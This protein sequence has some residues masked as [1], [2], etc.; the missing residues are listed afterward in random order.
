MGHTF[1]DIRYTSEGEKSVT[2]VR[3]RRHMP[4]RPL[5]VCR[6]C[7]TLWPCPEAQRELLFASA[8]C[9]AA[10]RAHL[11]TLMVEADRQLTALRPD[12]APP[13]AVLHA[14][15]LGWLP[16]RPVKP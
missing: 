7:V 11:A 2:S 5:W 10:L 6:V 13:F 14:R 12:T 1:R 4:L 9:L 16:H 15:F 8:G 3:E